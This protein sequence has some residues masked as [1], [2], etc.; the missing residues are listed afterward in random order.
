MRMANGWLALWA[1]LI[2]AVGINQFIM[3]VLK[4]LIDNEIGHFRAGGK[5]SRLCLSPSAWVSGLLAISDLPSTCRLPTF[6]S[7]A[8]PTVSR[9]GGRLIPPLAV[10]W[11]APPSFQRASTRTRV[12]IQDAV[13]TAAAQLFKNPRERAPD[14]LAR[15]QIQVFF[16]WRLP[17]CAPGGLDLRFTCLALSRPRSPMPVS[18]A[19]WKGGWSFPGLSENLLEVQSSAGRVT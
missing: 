13:Q 17:G 2:R 12:H 16:G 10:P 19:S 1:H 18:R 7:R 15:P 5:A 4:I 6:S 11:H 3:L 9:A 8:R 14:S